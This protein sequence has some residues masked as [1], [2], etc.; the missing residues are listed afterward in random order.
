[1]RDKETDYIDVTVNCTNDQ[2]GLSVHHSRI[3]VSSVRGEQLDGT[4]L[5]SFTSYVHWS[6]LHG[7]NTMIH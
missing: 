6:H 3:E 7:A 2:W 4:C 1:M 5:S